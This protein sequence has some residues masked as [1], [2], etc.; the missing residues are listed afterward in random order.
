MIQVV[1]FHW[2]LCISL[3]NLILVDSIAQ[4]EKSS[5]SEPRSSRGSKS[6]IILTTYPGQSGINPLLMNWGHPS[7]HL[8][9]P[10]VV[11]RNQRTVRRRNGKASE[12][13]YKAEN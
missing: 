4:I 5:V 1:L 7:P 6:R 3:L 11:S 12:N 2:L 9:G 10:V 8:R 13:T